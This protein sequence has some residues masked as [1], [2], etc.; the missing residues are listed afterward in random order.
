ML[1]AILNKDTMGLSPL[2]KAGGFY[3]SGWDSVPIKTGLSA[4]GNKT[5]ARCGMPLGGATMKIK[6]E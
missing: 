6:R 3:F 4:S 5:V 2:R 1:P